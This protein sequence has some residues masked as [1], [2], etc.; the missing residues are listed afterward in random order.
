M[1]GAVLWKGHWRKEKMRGKE[2]KEIDIGLG[3]RT[4]RIRIR[5]YKYG[6][7]TLRAVIVTTVK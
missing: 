7:K 6:T 5:P 4:V 1:G 3:L 2:G